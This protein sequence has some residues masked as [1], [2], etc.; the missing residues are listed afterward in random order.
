[1][2]PRH[3]RSAAESSD[4]EAPEA[5]TFGSSKQ[6]AKGDQQSIQQYH[7]AEKQRLKEK[8]RAIDRA[9]K[10]RSAKTKQGRPAKR[11]RNQAF[12]S[13]EHGSDEDEDEDNDTGGHGP[14]REA[15]EDRM[16]RAMKDAEEESDLEGEHDDEMSD[17]EGQ[18]SSVSEEASSGEEDSEEDMDDNE[19]NVSGDGS[20]D[21]DEDEDM[22]SESADDEDL[23]SPSSAKTGNYLPEHLFKSALKKPNK[24]VFNEVEDVQER[25]SQSMKPKKRKRPGHSSKDIIVGFVITS[26]LN[27]VM[28]F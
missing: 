1:M 23:L 8:N 18:G 20:D 17:E 7:I 22:A 16:A 5:V 28:M 9:L 14:T 13:E 3:H 25:H 11:S 2:A 26:I 15:L 27:E 6:T 24:I 12:P 4:D 10:E 21:E 19:E